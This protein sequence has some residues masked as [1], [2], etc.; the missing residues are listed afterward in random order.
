MKKSR[1][2]ETQIV[3][4]LKEVEAGRLVKEVCREY[5]ISDATYYNWKAKYGGM[6]VSDIRRLKELE[7]ENRRDTL[8]GAYNR[9]YFDEVL[10]GMINDSMAD[11]EPLSLMFIDADHFKQVNDVHGHQ[12]GDDVLKWLA[13]NLR[14][15]V[16]EADIVVRY[17]GEEF[18]A[19]LP[20]LSEEDATALGKHIVQS[21]KQSPIELNGL[22]LSITVSIGIATMSN[23]AH[24]LSSRELIVAADQ[25]MYFS[26]KT[27]RNKCSPASV[28]PQQRSA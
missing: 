19:I 28:L 15:L 24:I 20:A 26:K 14:A 6:E 7:E 3:K 5:G 18:V 17:G 12:V 21:I 9:L 13:K 27:G 25:A 2:A 8:T 22:G 4:I 23:S 11:Q 1:Y 10:E 16:R